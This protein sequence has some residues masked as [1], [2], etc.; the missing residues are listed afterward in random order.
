MAHVN[1]TTF[2]THSDTEIKGFFGPYRWLSN[3][4]PCTVEFDGLTYPSTEN[5][6][7]A[8]KII[9]EEREVLAECTPN[10]SKKLWKALTKIDASDVEWNARRYEMMKII[11][12][13]KYLKHEDLRKMLL[14]T[15][16]KYLEETNYWGDVYWGVDIKK[17]GENQLGQLLMNVRKYFRLRY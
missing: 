5:A 16:E 11:T 10:E 7:Q 17:G 6:Y 3:F 13:E 8:S 1:W 12:L 2:S 4:H 15:G 9:P 14:D